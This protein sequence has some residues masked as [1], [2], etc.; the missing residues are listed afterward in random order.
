MQKNPTFT[1]VRELG[2]FEKN[3][4]DVIRASLVLTHGRPSFDVR[5]YGRKTNGDLAHSHRGVCIP[6]E[7]AHD[8]ADTITRAAHALTASDFPTTG[9]A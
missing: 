6:V 8:F 1:V 2:S 3:E 9:A 5:V 4:R 7:R